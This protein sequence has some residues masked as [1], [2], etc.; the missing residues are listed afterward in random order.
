MTDESELTLYTHTLDDNP[1]AG[2]H[3]LAL[4]YGVTIYEYDAECMRQ[5]DRLANGSFAVPQEWIR[6]SRR[7]HREAAA[8][9]G[10]DPT[11]H[12]VLAHLKAKQTT[13]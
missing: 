1:V 7:H 12:E 3:D 9:L 6:T 11:V 13:E 4:L 5:S 2:I 8:V 10:H